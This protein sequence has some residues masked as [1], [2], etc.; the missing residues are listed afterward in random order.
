MNI[1]MKGMIHMNN[2]ACICC[3]L[4]DCSLC[5]LGPVCLDLLH[6][7]AVNHTDFRSKEGDVEWP[8]I[9]HSIHAALSELSYLTCMMLSKNMIN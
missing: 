7:P 1:L 5:I 2:D 9:L 8:W 4:T 3:K 6:P